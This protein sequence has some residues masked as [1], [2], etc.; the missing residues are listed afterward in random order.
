MREKIFLNYNE[1]KRKIVRASISV[2][3][4]ILLRL[5]KMLIISYD[6]RKKLHDCFIFISTSILATLM[7]NV[8]KNPWHTW[9]VSRL[10]ITIGGK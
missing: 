1:N 8:G 4:F 2:R 10:L 3:L 7:I 9:R 6:V 5:P